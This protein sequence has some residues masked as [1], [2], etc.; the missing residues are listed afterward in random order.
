MRLR[1]DDRLARAARYHRRRRC[2]RGQRRGGCHWAGVGRA[3]GARGEA[4]RASGYMDMLY[5]V[6]LA[7]EEQDRAQGLAHVR[8][9]AGHQS[10]GHQPG[11]LP[12][13]D[14][15]GGGAA[16]KLRAVGG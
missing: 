15:A 11:A 12:H 16:A 6:L 13:H 10:A 9:A 4:G 5:A 7:E 2:R 1:D 8:H 14:P 3:D